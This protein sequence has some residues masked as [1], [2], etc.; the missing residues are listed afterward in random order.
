M[1]LACGR[2]PHKGWLVDCGADVAEGIGVVEAGAG[3]VLGG[4]GL[5]IQEVVEG[6]VE[7]VV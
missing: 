1:V 4:S 2:N 6:S 5:W 3:S 7:A